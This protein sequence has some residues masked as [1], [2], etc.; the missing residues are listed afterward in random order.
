MARIAALTDIFDALPGEAF[1]NSPG[2]LQTHPTSISTRLTS[3]ACPR[4][5]TR[6][7][8]TRTSTRPPRAL[9]CHARNSSRPSRDAQ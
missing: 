9:A 4:N 1:K 6:T 5:S 8:R 7:P 3:T 2:F